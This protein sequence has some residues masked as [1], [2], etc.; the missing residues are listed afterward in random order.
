MDLLQI[1]SALPQVERVS[2]WKD[3]H[4]ITLASA[5]GSRARSDLNTKIW[6][7]GDVLTIETAKGVSS[8]AWIADKY[9]LI[10][11]V[12]AAGGKVRAI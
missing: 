10:E 8:D 6:A 9:A 4:Y 2:P 1:I 5:K 7:K 12:E 11:A 3:R